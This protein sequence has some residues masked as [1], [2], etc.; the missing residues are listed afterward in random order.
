MSQSETERLVNLALLYTTYAIRFL[1]IR[2]TTLCFATLHEFPET[3]LSCPVSTMS[4][5]DGKA[6]SITLSH[7]RSVRGGISKSRSCH[8]IL[9]MA[10]KSSSCD[11][12]QMVNASTRELGSCHPGLYSLHPCQ[13]ISFSPCAFASPVKNPSR[14]RLGWFLRNAIICLKNLNSC[15]FRSSSLQSN[16]LI[17]LSWQ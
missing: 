17:S 16:Q 7:C 6:V 5:G 12:P 13:S 11:K 4:L 3:T 15:R 8:S 2:T 9:R 10:C 14:C 1:E